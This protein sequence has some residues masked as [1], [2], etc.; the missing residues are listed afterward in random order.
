M[1]NVIDVWET[2]G[3]RGEG[4]KIRINDEG[5]DINNLEFSDRFD[6]DNSCES[7][8][9]ENDSMD[10]GTIVAGIVVGNADNDACAAGIAHKATFS[11]CNIFPDP[12]PNEF[13]DGGQEGVEFDISQ[14]S[15]GIP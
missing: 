3:L 13:L 11:S 2:Y 9:P 10:H 1:I 15:L 5:V 6:L 8:L 4:I 7:Y 12:K 14:N